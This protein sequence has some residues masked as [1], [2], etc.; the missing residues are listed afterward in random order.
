MNVQQV[1][2]N[3]GFKLDDSHSYVLM[4]FLSLCADLYCTVL[5]CDVQYCTVLYYIVLFNHYFTELYFTI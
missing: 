3:L 4:D 1:I 2:S 5:Y